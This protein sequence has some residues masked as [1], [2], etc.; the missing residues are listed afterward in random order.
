MGRLG[1]GCDECVVL[2]WMVFGI[3]IHGVNR[4]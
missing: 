3:A 1:C 4:L 2:T